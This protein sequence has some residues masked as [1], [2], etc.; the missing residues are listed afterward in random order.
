MRPQSL[1]IVGLCLLVVTGAPGFSEMQ[2]VQP[3]YPSLRWSRGLSGGIIEDSS[4]TLYDL[5]GDG[6]LEVV[7]GTTNKRNI[8][9]NVD[10]NA[11]SVL[12]VLEDDGAIK[13]Q[14]SLLDP[15]Y[16]SPAVV[17]I[18]YPP[19]DIPEVLVT[20]GGDV[21]QCRGSIIAFNRN[22]NQLWKY[23]TQD[24]QGT[25]T[26]CGNWSSP[27]VGDL[28][29]DGDMEIVFGSWDRN[30][31]MLNHLGQYQWHYHVADSVW[32][33]AA[34]ADLDR[35]GDLEIIIGTDI[36]GG[37]VL[38]DG[39]QPTDGGFVL[40]LDKDG[41]KLARRQMNE[42]IYSS[43][44]VGDMDGDGRKEIF[45][46]TGMYWYRQGKYTQPYVYG[47]RVNMSGSEWIMEDLPGWPRPMA[48]PGMSSPALA[49]L[50]NDGDLEIIIGT[51]Y[52][53][54]SE[55]NQCPP[56]CYGAIYAWH[57]SGN[58]VSGFP[59]WPRDYMSK[60]GFVRSSPTVADVDGD[61]Q[62][63]ILFSMN[64]DVIVV[65]P[66]GQQENILHTAWSLFSS[67]AI[68]DLDNDGRTDMIIG[69]SASGDSARGYVYAFTFGN[70]S[71]NPV[72]QP[73]PMFHR[74]S[75]HT[76]RYL[77]LPQLS[78]SPSSLF[79][80]H[81]YGSGSYERAYL[82]LTNLGD[83]AA[84]W[85]VASSPSGV[86]VTPFTGTLFY[87]ATVPLTITVSTAGYLTGTH[88]LGQIVIT[89]TWSGGAI[90]NSPATIPVTLYVGQVHRVYL[91]VVL[92]AAR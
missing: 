66:N 56:T 37:G 89:G 45:V 19:D 83:Y 80:L 8:S 79:V 75:R 59:M 77:R 64:W 54:M 76:G 40:I 27:T 31:Y 85:S 32:S 38:P 30:I 22:G 88:L 49:D 20:T 86:M 23:D 26:P 13:W 53:G 24:A 43:P 39:Y 72:L 92:R 57:H 42:A 46:G 71:Y 48:Y 55:P 4:P 63:E 25:G 18:S 61:G 12:A 67:P 47:F 41:R 15:M 81:Q 78:V 68:G 17:D 34:L 52:D 5:D 65:G 62:L 11:Q 73:W 70:N 9:G 16:S 14:A 7:I 60:N 91:P 50:D 82:R 29:G 51:G 3:A 58:S 1:V 90:Q 35:D 33:T 36:T 28:D 2:I 69:G 84:Q 21:D 6:K 10:K 87:T 44:A 74:D